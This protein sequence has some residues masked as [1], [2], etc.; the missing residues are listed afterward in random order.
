M[1][2]RRF[3]YFVLAAGLFLTLC[4][5]TASRA[6][7]DDNQQLKQ[8]LGVRV[9][10]GNYADSLPIIEKLLVTE[11]N[12]A[13]LHFDLG[14]ALIAKANMNSDGEQRQALRVRARSAFTRAKELGSNE[15]VL[16]AMIQALPPD[17]SDGKAFSQNREA[18]DAMNQGEALFSQG[19]LDEALADYQKALL[20]DPKL[21][22]AALFCGDVYTQK[23]DFNQA[24]ASYQKAIA[25]DPNRETA[26]RYSATPLMKQ[27]KYD[28]ARDRYIEAFIAE[29]YSKFSAAG[30]TQ[31][32]NVT[33][34]KV[35]HPAIDIPTTVTYDEKGDAKINLDGGALL[36]GGK[37]D[38]SFAWISYGGTRTL[39]HKEKFVKAFPNEKTYR[40][41]LAEETDAL[42]SVISVAT[43][44]KTPQPLN[45]SIAKLK[46]LNDQG[47]LESYILLAK[48]DEGISQDYPGYLKQNR[49][50]LRRYVVQYVVT[51]GGK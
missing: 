27:Q 14:F 12:S 19:K 45:P 3:L 4:F 6:Q 36:G 17:G 13:E 42:R 34:T 22:E 9:K 16:D 48:A 15:P 24:E 38:G 25:I 31:W 39:W 26:Y 11:P 21:Y 44:G 33:K 23:A 40:H 8:K 28:L 10:N 49:D 35:A 29:P 30:L 46:E 43:S 50:K 41:S 5:S 18:N 47:L 37:S 20:M 2:H 7:T 51:G 32:A 1:P